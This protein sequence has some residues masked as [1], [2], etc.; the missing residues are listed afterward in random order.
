MTVLTERPVFPP[1]DPDDLRELD[2]AAHAPAGSRAA[3]VTPDGI[4]LPLPE[5]VAEVLLQVVAAMRAGRAVTIAPL[6]QRLT[7][8]E[9]A[10]LLGIS[11]PTLIKLLDDG[12][13]PF[14]LLNGSRHRRI[15]LSDVLAYEHRRRAER[16]DI[17]TELVE[18][19]EEMG[20]Y[21]HADE[22]VRGH[23][24]DPA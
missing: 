15:L 13:I 8:Q 17:L 5:A 16:E 3:L 18:L 6:A 2:Q 10:V 20:L 7:T 4:E 23:G 1:K 24:T 22:D 9:A 11:R 19:G 12:K 21:D 14:E